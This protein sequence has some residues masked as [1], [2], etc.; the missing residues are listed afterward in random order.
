M[1]DFKQVIDSCA[2]STYVFNKRT[3]I[4]SAF[5]ERKAMK[6]KSTSQIMIQSSNFFKVIF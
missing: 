3:S 4:K 6:S 1:I 2:F 5:I